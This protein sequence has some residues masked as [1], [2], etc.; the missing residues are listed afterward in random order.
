M[1]IVTPSE[2]RE[3]EQKTF[4]EFHFNESQIIENVG[5]E[6]AFWLHENFLHKNNGTMSFIFLLGKGNNGADGLSIARHLMN[7]YGHRVKVMAFTLFPEHESSPEFKKQLATAESFGLRVAQIRS[8]DDIAAYFFHVVDETIIV[9]AL[10][11][12]GIRLPLANNIYDVIRFVNEN[13]KTIVSIDIATGV[14]GESGRTAGSAIKANYTLAIGAA[15]LGCFIADGVSHSGEIHLIEAG[16]PQSLFL[17]GDKFHIDPQSFSR[18]FF[19]RSKYAH[20]NSNGHTLVIGGSTGLT[21]ALILASQS[22]L[23]VGSGLVTAATWENNH[24]EYLVRQVPEIM[25]TVIPNDDTSWSSLAEKIAR[26]DSIVIGPGLG[27]DDR[28]K[29]LLRI[30]LTKYKGPL[31][32]DA[33]AIK[34]LDYKEDIALIANRQAPTIITPHLGELAELLKK[35]KETIYKDSINCLR[36]V[37]YKT[38]A[39]VLLKG[40]CTLVALPSGKVFFNFF[41][42]EAMATGGTGDVL[43]GILGGL[44]AQ[45]YAK[46]RNQFDAVQI[47]QSLSEQIVLM[48]IALHSE[49]GR[50]AKVQVGGRGMKASHLME[51]F[52]SAFSS[53]E[54]MVYHKTSTH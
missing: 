43:A 40:P 21:G 45:V 30:I 44:L 18:D 19:H 22:A 32:I 53:I 12:S 4:E 48:A 52:T 8:V 28:V 47:P 13:A 36:E 37:V 25:S 6:A 34:K 46:S 51:N 38:G 16:F 10:F 15:K 5:L 29:T 1:R 27:M 2:M 24:L 31:V 54:N 11:G 41:P 50:L 49:S 20:K 3:I 23:N 17:D 42:N 7:K 26:Y 35:P 39:I 14:E 9:D 33:D